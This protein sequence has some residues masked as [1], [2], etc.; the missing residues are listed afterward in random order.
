MTGLFLTAGPIVQVREARGIQV[1]SD[2]DRRVLYRGPLVVLVNRQSASA[3]EILAAAL[4]RK[5]VV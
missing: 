3:S 2:P 1:L 4:D 5:S